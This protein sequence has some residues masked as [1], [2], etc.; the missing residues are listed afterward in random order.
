MTVK[1]FL[2]TIIN[3]NSCNNYIPQADMP[4][5]LYAFSAASIWSLTLAVEPHPGIV[6]NKPDA[7]DGFCAFDWPLDSRAM[8]CSQVEADTPVRFSI[9]CAALEPVA[10]GV[11]PLPNFVELALWLEVDWLESEA[12][13]LLEVDWAEFDGAD[14][15]STLVLSDCVFDAT[16]CCC[17]PCWLYDWL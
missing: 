15:V 10:P 5:A 11:L 16:A 14:T 1:I 3:F 6:W 13:E 9:S 12:C 2:L 7:P 8:M 17:E 4:C